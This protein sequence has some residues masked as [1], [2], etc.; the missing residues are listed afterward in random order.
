MG[1]LVDSDIANMGAAAI[2]V[3]LLLRTIFD[4]INKQR[5]R[6]QQGLTSES[7]QIL[8]KIEVQVNELHQDQ[9][10][11]RTLQ[12]SLSK[13]ADAQEQQTDVLKQLA[14]LNKHTLRLL[15]RQLK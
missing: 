3:F 10:V 14:D 12:R 5:N 13:I 9:M 7:E 11:S 1:A 2:I 4:F 8:Q 6:G 15:E